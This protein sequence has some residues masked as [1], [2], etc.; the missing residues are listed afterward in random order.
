MISRAGGLQRL[1]EMPASA[2]QVMGAEKALFKHLR[3]RA[4]SPK[5][6]MIYR[7]PAVMALPGASGG[8]RPA[9][10]RRSSP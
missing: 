7:H 9:L 8:G 2:I 1:T 6:G 5:H 10:W 4:P 3:G